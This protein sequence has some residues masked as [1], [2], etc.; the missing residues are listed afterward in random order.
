[1]LFIAPCL[2]GGDGEC[3]KVWRVGEVI[4]KRGSPIALTNKHQSNIFAVAF[5]CDNR[6]VFS[7]GEI[8]LCALWC[9]MLVCRITAAS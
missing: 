2:L 3:V 4:N 9:I 8:Q 5:G 1:M 6:Y 7:G